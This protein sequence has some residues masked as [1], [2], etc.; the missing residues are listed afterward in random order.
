MFDALDARFYVNIFQATTRVGEAEYYVILKGCIWFFYVFLGLRKVSRNLA[1]TERG[2]FK[3][4]T[5]QK[6]ENMFSIRY[7]GR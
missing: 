2:E 5:D 1:S 3:S 6:S 4:R 7:L